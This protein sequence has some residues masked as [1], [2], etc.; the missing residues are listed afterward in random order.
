MVNY[1]IKDLEKI[2]GIKAHTIRI[3]EKRYGILKPLRTKTN[4]RFYSDQD[5]RLLMNIAVLN[6]HGYKISSLNNM[7]EDEVA[8]SVLDISHAEKNQTYN[9]DQLIIALLEL[10]EA[11]FNRSINAAIASSDFENVF[12]YLIP[13]FLEKVG[14]LW[15]TGSVSPAQ[16]HFMSNLI[17][18]KLIAATDH[19]DYTKKGTASFMLFLPEQEYHEIALLYFQYIIRKEGF[20]VFYLGQNVSLTHLNDAYLLNPVDYLL[21]SITSPVSPDKLAIFIS[22]VLSIHGK[23][24]V[25][26]G[27]NMFKDRPTFFPDNFHYLDTIQMLKQFLREI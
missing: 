19:L 8:K 21:T 24:P 12:E 14:I 3:W 22:S 6:K 9:V 23:K 17:R 13:Q 26:I 4:I 11:G 20:S 16:E 7:S 10:D 5:L 1:S 2:T 25:L 15:Q 27:G 18:Q